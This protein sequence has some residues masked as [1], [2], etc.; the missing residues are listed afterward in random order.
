MFV[1][2]RI[3]MIS[4]ISV[5]L[6]NCVENNFIWDPGGFIV[7]DSCVITGRIASFFPFVFLFYLTVDRDKK[8]STYSGDFFPLPPELNFLVL[9]IIFL[10]HM[11][12]IEDDV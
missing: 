9:F 2:L 12:Y 5:L 4:F 6:V 7:L 3:R 1:V 8:N 10:H 11:H